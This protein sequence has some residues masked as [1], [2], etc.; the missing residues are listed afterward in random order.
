MGN[1]IWQA[2]ETGYKYAQFIVWNIFFAVDYRLVVI[3]S[4]EDEDKS[5]II[6]RLHNYRRS[7]APKLVVTVNDAREYLKAHFVH[8]TDM[9][10]DSQAT[11]TSNQ[12]AS[13]VD[14]EK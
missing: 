12:R 2:E 5:H 13:M 1:R 6:S 9:E 3:C 4:K 11:P 8:Q 14:P 10:L 7:V